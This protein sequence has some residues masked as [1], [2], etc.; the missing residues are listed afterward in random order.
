MFDFYLDYLLHAG[1][2][3]S[4]L[5]RSY[6]IQPKLKAANKIPL[7]SENKPRGLYYSKAFL[8]A[9]TRRSLYLRREISASKSIWL[10]LYL[11]GNLPFLLCFT[12][13]LTEISKYKPPR[14]VGAYILRGDLTEG[15][16]R[17]EFKRLII[18]GA[19][20]QN[21]TVCNMYLV[22]LFLNIQTHNLVQHFTS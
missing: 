1:K 8:R 5:L 10:A 3:D 15:F 12:L 4:V 13:Y 21:F 6:D 19:Y 22:L 7:N 14:E 11:E 20:F 9:Y 2:L 18:G 17:Y 16:L